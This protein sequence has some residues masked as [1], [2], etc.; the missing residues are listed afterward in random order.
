MTVIYTRTASLY[1]KTI[2]RKRSAIGG[3][4]RRNRAI[5]MQD[6]AHAQVR[7][8]TLW[9]D[10]PQRYRAHVCVLYPMRTRS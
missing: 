2:H 8:H 10:E 6:A 3:T 5:A 1:R 4:Q 9:R 7:A